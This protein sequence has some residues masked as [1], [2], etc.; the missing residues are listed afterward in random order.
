MSFSA[1]Y[2]GRCGNCDN[3]I[4]PGDEVR[5]DDDELVH[6]QCPGESGPGDVCIYCWC[7]HR[8]ECA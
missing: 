6:D 1:R 5:Y 3:R 2:A 7:I 4:E 8:G